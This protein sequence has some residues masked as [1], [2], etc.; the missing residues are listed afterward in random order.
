MKSFRRALLL[1]LSQ[2]AIH[3]IPQV[4]AT[5]RLFQWLRSSGFEGLPEDY[6]IWSSEEKFD[7]WNHTLTEE[8]TSRRGA[9]NNAPLSGE[10]PGLLEQLQFLTTDDFSSTFDRFRDDLAYNHVKRI[11][12][13]GAVG[14]VSWIP[15]SASDSENNNHSYTGYFATGTPH[16]LIRLSYT[17]PNDE[18]GTTP[19]LA[20][21]IFRDGM[22]SSNLLAM[23]SLEGQSSGNF[24]EFDFSNHLAPASTLLLR[25]V[26]R[27][28]SRYSCP[29]T[30]T[31]L[32]EIATSTE[33]IQNMR[34]NRPEI[35]FP[36]QV[37]LR[38]NPELTERFSDFPPEG[39][40]FDMLTAIDVGTKLYDIYAVAG[41]DDGAEMEIHV[42]HL[43]L[44][45]ELQP[46]LIGDRVLFFRHQKIEEDY[47]M[48]P[49]YNAVRDGDGD[50]APRCPAGYSLRS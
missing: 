48:E 37:I 43:E 31:G 39:D 36:Y 30:R 32:S 3:P 46:S 2:A 17:S 38:P 28:F 45:K 47:Q 8:A 27:R 26:S 13:V 10:F 14:L 15:A 41:P 25:Y 23:E 20:L 50:G 21:K 40:L 19:G 42:G 16:A 11:R 35:E 22:P 29:S 18:S 9:N 12:S 1:L 7:F 44:T 5:L 4:S 34:N 49:S 33:D 24:F 6:E